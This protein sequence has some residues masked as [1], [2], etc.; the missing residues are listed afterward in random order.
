MVCRVRQEARYIMPHKLFII[1]DRTKTIYI[2]AERVLTPV[3]MN[4]I[5]ENNYRVFRYDT[6]MQC[7]E[8]LEPSF[9]RIPP[10]NLI[11]REILG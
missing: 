11:F 10:K 9:P 7:A 4:C 3:M 5:R 2:G 6:R 1:T 8:E